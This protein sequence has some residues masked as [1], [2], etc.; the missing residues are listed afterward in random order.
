MLTD[1]YAWIS[2]IIDS[3]VIPG[4]ILIADTQNELISPAK[5]LWAKMLTS[6]FH[7]NELQ[8][9]DYLLKRYYCCFSKKIHK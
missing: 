8:Y 2:R 4:D 7:E 9:I 5:I 6:T 3:D 1:W